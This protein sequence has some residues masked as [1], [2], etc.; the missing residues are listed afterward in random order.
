MFK[1]INLDVPMTRRD[2]YNL[3]LMSL[4]ITAVAEVGIYVW[5]RYQMNQI[6]KSYFSPVIL[7]SDHNTDT[8]EDEDDD[9]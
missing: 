2:Y 9:E 6:E 8:D 3:F 1:K 4:A 7:K 5:Y